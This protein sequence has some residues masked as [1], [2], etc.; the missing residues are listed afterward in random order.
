MMRAA[1]LCGALLVAV[2]LVL[3]LP[4]MHVL[5]AGAVVGLTAA[6]SVVWRSPALAAVASVAALLVF[7]VVLLFAPSGGH[8]VEAVLLGSGLLVLLDGTYFELRFRAAEAMGQIAT[9]Y[10]SSLFR[11]IL[12]TAILGVLTAAIAVVMAGELDASVRPII[13]A[14]GGILIVVGIVGKARSASQ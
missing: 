2:S 3:T 10:L 7:S 6:L 11:C 1:G 13:A 9:D 12:L 14:F 4:D 8:V 5:E